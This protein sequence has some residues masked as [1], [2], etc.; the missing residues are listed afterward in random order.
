MIFQASN[1]K[2][3]E[4][5]EPLDDGSNI[6]KPMYS[7]ES[8]WLKYFSHSNLLYVRALRAIVN[9]TPIGEYHLRFFPR[10]EFTCSC[11]QY[12]IETRYHILYKC[13]QFN[14]YWNLKWDTVAH[15]TL[16]L[17]FNSKAFSEG[18]SI[19]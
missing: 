11:G 3:R 1:T 10:E 5:L 8:S 6:I 16:F 17:E 2:E 9:H 13:K 4:F 18:E 12:L 7:K 15:F 19:T 14:K